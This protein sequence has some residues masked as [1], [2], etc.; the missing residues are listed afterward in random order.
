MGVEERGGRGEATS[1]E[2]ELPKFW[3]NSCHVYFTFL[4]NS[5][6]YAAQFRLSSAAY[7]RLRSSYPY[8]SSSSHSTH[9]SATNNVTNNLLVTS[10]RQTLSSIVRS[11]LVCWYVRC[12]FQELCR[13]KWDVAQSERIS[14]DVVP[15]YIWVFTGRN[16]RTGKIKLNILFR[17]SMQ[18]WT[19]NGIPLKCKSYALRFHRLYRNLLS[20]GSIPGRGV[21]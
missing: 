20:K 11:K 5:P 17:Q 9:F 12:S 6:I 18:S 1:P 2:R 13:M 15:R 8:T 16:L 10:K 3:W 19:S 14:G 4:V 7:N 21:T